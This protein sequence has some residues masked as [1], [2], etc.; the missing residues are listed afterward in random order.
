MSFWESINKII[1][2][3]HIQLFVTACA[4]A[5][6]LAL[7]FRKRWKW[8]LLFAALGGFAWLW[9]W[10]SAAYSARY[11]SIFLIPAAMLTAGGMIVL[12]RAAV[13]FIP[14]AKEK[15]QRFCGFC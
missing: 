13:H 4:G 6:F 15:K 7:Y 5:V 3:L 8:I 14:A 10:A 2:I 11:Y 9:R 12:A 1:E